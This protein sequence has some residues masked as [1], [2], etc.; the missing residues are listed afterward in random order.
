LNEK[1]LEYIDIPPADELASSIFCYRYDIEAS[2]LP[3]GPL[4]GLTRSIASR[5]I[6]EPP[7]AARHFDNSLASARGRGPAGGPGSG[8]KREGSPRQLEPHPAGRPV[9]ISGH[10]R[11]AAALAAGLDRAHIV[12]MDLSGE[13]AIGMWLECAASGGPP[14]EL[15]KIILASRT[16]ELAGER[17]DGFLEPLSL[18]F[19]RNLS[20]DFTDSL[21]RLLGLPE[22]LSGAL[23]E[24][25]VSTGDLLS[26]SS[27]PGLDTVRAARLI[28]G[29][30][31]STGGR[32]E[33][34]RLLLYLADQGHGTERSSPAQDLIDGLE[35]SCPDL[36]EKLRK[37]C[38]P[39]ME[40][41]LQEISDIISGMHLPNHVSLTPPVNMEG[42]AYRMDIRI[43]TEAGLRTALEKAGKALDSGDFGK[44]LDILKGK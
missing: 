19:G 28:A 5:G 25:R 37:R 43:R 7:L 30:G 4:A 34:V 11:L 3:S 41:D 8:G 15:E 18:I 9:I 36:L 39:R 26:L 32:K 44:L 40:N 38:R 29:A 1:T 10:R 42:G 16:R 35:G 20:A 2:V 13:D 21:S 17:F 23:H 14:S 22:D 12:L 6:I 31:M 27:H 33:A 24:G